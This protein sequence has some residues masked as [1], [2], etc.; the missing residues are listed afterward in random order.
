MKF[1]EIKRFFIP[2]RNQSAKFSAIEARWHTR[3]GREPRRHGLA[4]SRQLTLCEAGGASA[5]Q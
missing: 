5:A 1:T 3:K 4:S 2:V